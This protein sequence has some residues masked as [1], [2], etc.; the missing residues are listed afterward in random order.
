MENRNGLV[1]DARLTQATGTAEPRSGAWTC[2]R[3]CRPAAR[4]TV[5]ADKAY[6]AAILCR[7]RELG[8]TPHVAQNID[9]TRLQYR[10]A[11]HAA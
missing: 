2:W 11:N 9:A 8:V 1:V 4:I 7:M 6:D 3:I 10:R 5:G